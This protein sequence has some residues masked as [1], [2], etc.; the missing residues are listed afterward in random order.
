MY[1]VRFEVYPSPA[2]S[3]VVP[4]VSLLWF[5]VMGRI[6]KDMTGSAA[7]VR[8]TARTLNVGINTVIRTLK[9]SR[10]DE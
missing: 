8:E 4:V 9:N 10:H 5:I 7:G 3:V 1:N 2:L 6:R